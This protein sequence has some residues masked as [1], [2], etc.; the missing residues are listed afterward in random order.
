MSL[1]FAARHRARLHGLILADTRAAADSEAGRQGRA[2]AIARVEAQGVAA[3]VESQLAAL[4]SPGAG[5]GVREQVR[6]LGRQQTPQ[7]ILA[8]IR[9]LRDRPDRRGEL[10]EIRCPTLIVVG[11][12]DSIS[13]PAEMAAI[14]SAIAGAHLLVIHA[15]GHMSNLESPDAFLAAVSDFIERTSHD[16]TDHATDHATNA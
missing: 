4:L 3:L 8:G 12:L 2:Q 6:T 13:P 11:A 16:A 1:A 9:A 5:E 10:A 7:G 14:A 15:A